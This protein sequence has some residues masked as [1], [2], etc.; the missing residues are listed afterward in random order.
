ML[1]T[2]SGPPLSP[3]QVSDRKRGGLPA[4]TNVPSVSGC[5]SIHS[6]RRAGPGGVAF[7]V[8]RQMCGQ[9]STLYMSACAMHRGMPACRWEQSTLPG[10]ACC[11]VGSYAC[12]VMSS[13]T[14]WNC[15]TAF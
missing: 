2:S 4:I 3:F 7:Q 5:R 8:R 12:A 6:C 14:S 1:G 15:D 9:Q 11:N 10:L 13:I